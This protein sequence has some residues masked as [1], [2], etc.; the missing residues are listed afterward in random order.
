MIDPTAH[1][2]TR[3]KEHG[4]SSEGN[5]AGI[6]RNYWGVRWVSSVNQYL[7]YVLKY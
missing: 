4:F 1:H 7:I 6:P 2:S 3:N 5:G